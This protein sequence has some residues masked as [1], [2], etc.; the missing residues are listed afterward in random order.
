MTPYFQK[1]V[2]KA[3]DMQET[4]KHVRFGQACWACDDENRLNSTLGT[5]QD[6]FHWEDDRIE[7][8]FEILETL[9]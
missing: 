9:P 4:N 3:F 1:L 5:S 8:I 7:K 2:Q 6:F